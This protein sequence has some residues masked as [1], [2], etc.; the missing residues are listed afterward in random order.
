MNASTQAPNRQEPVSGALKAVAVVLLILD[1]VLIALERY[2]SGAFIVPEFIGA[3][4]APIIIAILIVVIA[5]V[6]KSARSPRA[7]AKIAIGTLAFIGVGTCGGLLTAMTATSGGG[8]SA[9]ELATLITRSSA[10][11]RFSIVT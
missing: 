3:L 8:E 9:A 7:A 4:L 11:P 2:A 5:R 6:F 10:A 1:M